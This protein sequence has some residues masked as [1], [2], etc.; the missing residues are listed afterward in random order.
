MNSRIVNAQSAELALN[1]SICASSPPLLSPADD[2]G[3]VIAR[4]DISIIRLR[5]IERNRNSSRIPVD[6]SPLSSS[7]VRMMARASKD[8]GNGELLRGGIEGRGEGNARRYT[9]RRLRPNEPNYP[10]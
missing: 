2:V 4:I 6:F 9:A 1:R 3:I 5:I 7:R 8:N 10:A